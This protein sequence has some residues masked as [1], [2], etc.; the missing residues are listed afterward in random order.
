MGVLCMVMGPSGSGKST[1][2]LNMARDDVKVFGAT[3]KRL[4][5]RT[6]MEVT[7]RAGYRD[8]YEALQANQFHCYVVDDSTYLMQFDNFRHAKEKGFD[9]YVQMALSFETL[10]EAAMDTDDDTVV[11][12]LHHPQ[13][14]DSGASK[15]QTVGKML[16]AQLCVEGLFDIIFECAIVEGKHVFWTNEHGIAKTPLNMFSE[17]MIPNDLSVVDSTMREFWGLAPLTSKRTKAVA[18]KAT[19]V[20]GRDAD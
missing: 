1:S 14:I 13:F 2:L 5:F 12:F 17:Q 4:P 20:G 10:L 19:K 6:P 7:K 16:D 3:A 15:P 18:R 11:Y 9:K 8:I